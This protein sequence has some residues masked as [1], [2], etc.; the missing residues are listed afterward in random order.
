MVVP[1]GA[2]PHRAPTPYLS[3]W[4]PLGRPRGILATMVAGA[5]SVFVGRARELAELEGALD[6][7]RAGRGAAV[8]LGGDAGIGK[9]RLVSELAQRA[10]AAGFVVLLGHSL[11]LAGTELPYHPFVEAL[12]PWGQPWGDCRRDRV[13]FTAASIRAHAVA[14]RGTR[15]VRPSAPGA[16]GRA[17][18][19]RLD[20]RPDRL[21]G[22][23]R[24]HPPGPAGRNRQGRRDRL[25]RPHPDPRRRDPAFGDRARGRPGSSRHRRRLGPDRGGEHGAAGDGRGRGDRGPLGGEPVLR[26]GTA[27]GRG[28]RRVRAAPSQPA[29]PAAA[30]HLRARPGG[31]RPAAVGFRSGAGRGLRRAV[32]GGR[33]AGGRRTPV[34]AAGRGTRDPRRRAG[35]RRRAVPALA[36]GGG[37]VHD[38]P[39]GRARG[40]PRAG[41]GRTW[42]PSPTHLLRSWPG[43]GRPPAA[44]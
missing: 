39:A 14:A 43:T 29:R 3:R 11:D 30:P 13:R 20:D 40:P 44:R 4:T 34:P 18:G 10:R 36:A 9:T 33:S 24:R 21:S 16:R 2:G 37:R 8:L 31:A 12:R 6:D 23:S 32:Q 1:N 38:S 28:Q 7:A 22:P 27:H 26:R 15:G 41:R 35:Q 25:P 19:R 17:L 5:G 42:R